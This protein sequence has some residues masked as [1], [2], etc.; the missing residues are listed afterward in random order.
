MWQGGTQP[1]S[2]YIFL[3]REGNANYELGTVFNLT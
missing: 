1:G 3:Y 2:K